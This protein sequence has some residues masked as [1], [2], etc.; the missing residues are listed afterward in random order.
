MNKDDLDMIFA[1][2]WQRLVRGKA[3][4]HSAFHTPV[5]ASVDCEGAPQQ[6]VMVLRKVDKDA[7]TLR[8]HTDARSAKA[9]QLATNARVSVIGYD[10]GAKIQIRVSGHGRVETD[11][12]LAVDSWASSVPSSRR[13][14]LA[15]V[16]PGSKTDAPTSGLPTHVENRVPTLLETEPGRINFAVLVV[17][18]DHLE[19]LYLASD[20]H[21]RA[22]FVRRDDGWQGQWLVP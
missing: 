1:D 8:F 22:E 5:V 16:A 2:I 21:R 6:R 9:V 13:C 18:M 15:E 10:A 3:D 4:R 20:G 17:E 14:Y 11:T 7:A 12:A 19:W